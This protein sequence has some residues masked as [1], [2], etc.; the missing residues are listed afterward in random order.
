MGKRTEQTPPKKTQM[1]KGNQKYT[2]LVT[3][4]MPI[5]TTRN[6]TKM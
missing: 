4:E 6:N 2:Q 1:T 3:R 5:K